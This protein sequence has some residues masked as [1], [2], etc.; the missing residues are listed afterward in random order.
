MTAPTGL[1]S[2]AYSL[3]HAAP[4]AAA[5]RL[6]ACHGIRATSSMA[7]RHHWPGPVDVVGPVG[8]G[9][10]RAPRKPNPSLVAPHPVARRAHRRHRPGEPR[11]QDAF[12]PPDLRLMTTLA[13]SLS[14]A[15]ENARLFRDQRPLDDRSAPPSWR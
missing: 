9:P 6:V 12:T 3:E 8:G 2:F 14:V 1:V 10:F 4:G 5:Q 13:S 7:K 11:R 15:L